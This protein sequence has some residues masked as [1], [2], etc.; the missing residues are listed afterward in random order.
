MEYNICFFDTLLILNKKY[1]IINIYYTFP[2]L[3][4]KLELI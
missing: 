1:Q 3:K 4:L 2:S